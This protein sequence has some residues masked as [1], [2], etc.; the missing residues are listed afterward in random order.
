MAAE[1]L[2][3]LL[4]GRGLASR[5]EAETWITGGRVSVNG[6]VVR[7]LG[8]KVEAG[9]DRVEVD[10]VPI[11]GERA[12][13][14]VVLNKPAGYVT[15]VRDPHAEHTVMELLKGLG[16]RVYPVGRLDRETRGVL[17]LTDDGDLAHALL[18]PSR[19]VEKVYEV[20]ATGEFTDDLLAKLS[21]GVELEDG[22]V[23]RPVKISS[24]RKTAGGLRF[25]LALKEGHKR[26]VRQM[27]RAV[28]GRVVEL[29]RVSFGGLTV[30]GMEEGAWRLLKRDEVKKL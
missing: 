26:Q 11:P 21:A 28:G 7:E 15:T 30:D 10:G 22:H 4:A 9:V 19:G 8:T 12:P 3:K 2:Q 13:I 20:T 16:R 6:E 1:R 14:V 24:V 18:H 29:V 25:L 17:V 27:L 5:R 23:T